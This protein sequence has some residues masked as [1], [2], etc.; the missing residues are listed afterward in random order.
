MERRVDKL[1][2]HGDSCQHFS[3]CGAVS[4]L[5][6]PESTAAVSNDPL[7]VVL[8]L[9]EYSTQAKIT[10]VCIQ[11]VVP[12]LSRKSQNGGSDERVS[13]KKE[14][15]RALRSPHEGNVLTGQCYLR[16]R[17]VSKTGDKPPA[18]SHKSQK[19]ADNLQAIWNRPALDVLYLL[20]ITLQSASADDMAQKRN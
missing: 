6:W 13:Q 3:L 11:H 2:T 15:G 10:S 14:S 16:L 1:H 17:D 9:A 5:R 19:L 4:T 12:R 18:I 20:R 8:D 7:L